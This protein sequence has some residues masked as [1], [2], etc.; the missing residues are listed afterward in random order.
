MTV[1]AGPN[2]HRVPEERM[3]VNSGPYWQGM[4]VGETTVN[5]IINWLGAPEGRM[6]VEIVM[7]DT[8]IMMRDCL[9]GS[10]LC[11]MTLTF[12]HIASSILKDYCN[13][14]LYLHI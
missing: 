9:D 13:S 10:Q 5:T 12:G 7:V 14:Y 4:L 11:R 3:T 6:P 8:R 2:W 1:A